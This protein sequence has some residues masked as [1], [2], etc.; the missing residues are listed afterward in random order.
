M[1]S[2]STF[3]CGFSET[4]VLHL[5]LLN[6]LIYFTLVYIHNLFYAGLLFSPPMTDFK[7]GRLF[8]ER[9]YITALDIQEELKRSF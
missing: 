5:L 2:F 9:C 7:K 4:W 3:S 6:P 1:V 8:Q